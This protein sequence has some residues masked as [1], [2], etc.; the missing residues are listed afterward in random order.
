MRAGATALPVG[1]ADD[2]VVVD[3]KVVLPRDVWEAVE[4]VPETAAGLFQI[5]RPDRTL[6]SLKLRVGYAG[7]PDLAALRDTVAASVERIVGVRPEIDL[8]ANEELL[9]LGPPHKIPRTAKA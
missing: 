7:A 5:I 2:E 4:C 6:T 3:G 1:G 8:V 9:K